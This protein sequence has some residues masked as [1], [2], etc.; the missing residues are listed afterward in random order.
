MCRK[1]YSLTTTT[2]HI[3]WSNKEFRTCT[4]GGHY[5]YGPSADKMSSRPIFQNFIIGEKP[6]IFFQFQIKIVYSEILAYR[7]IFLANGS[8]SMVNVQNTRPVMAKFQPFRF[9]VLEEYNKSS[10]HV[11]DICYNCVMLLNCYLRLSF[12]TCAG[13]R[14]HTSGCP[15]EERNRVW[16]TL[17]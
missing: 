7:I 16:C 8:Y 15:S 5:N 4:N 14:C 17:D 3:A 10:V 9:C 1:K 12:F 13:S 6:K 2:R 11:S